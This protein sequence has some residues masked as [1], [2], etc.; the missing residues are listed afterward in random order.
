MKIVVLGATGL[1]GR[2]MLQVLEERNFGECEVI[3]AASPRSIGKTLPFAG[4]TLTVVSPQD[5]IAAQPDYA[6][7]SAG[8]SASRQYAPMFAEV[9]CTVIDNSSAWRMDPGQE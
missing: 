1:V 4:R 8:A 5:A 6:V 9:G 2:T 7:F 3:P